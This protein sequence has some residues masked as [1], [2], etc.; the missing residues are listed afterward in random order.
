MSE[1]DYRSSVLL[2]AVGSELAMTWSTDVIQPLV[3]KVNDQNHLFRYLFWAIV[4]RS[5]SGFS[6]Y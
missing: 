6:T 3:K 4:R 1:G 5:H 2:M